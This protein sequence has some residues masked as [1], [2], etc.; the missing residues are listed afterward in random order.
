MV[1]RAGTSRQTGSRAP[2]ARLLGG[3]LLLLVLGTAPASASLLPPGFFDGPVAAGAGG[4]RVEADHMNYDAKHGLVSA[5]GAVR[6]SYQGNVISADRIEYDPATGDVTA[7]G[8]VQ[9]V[10]AGGNRYTMDSLRITGKTKEAFLD[11]L[12]ITTPEGAVITAK[13]AHYGEALQT[14]FTDATYSP[15]GLCVDSKG[16]KIGWKV[17]AAR[18]VYDRQNA[19]VSAEQPSLELL[20]VPVAWIPWFWMPDPTQPRKSGI[21]M[22][23]IGGDANRGVALT[24]PYFVPAGENIDIILSPTLMSR[25][26]FLMQGD[27]AV[28]FPGVGEIDVRGSAVDQLD[29]GAYAGTV[30]NRSWRG[31][32]QTT[33]RF[34]PAAD[35]TAGWSYSTFTDNQYL[36]DYAYDS[37][38]LLTNTLYATELS[39]QTWFDARLLSFHQLGNFT[40][41]DDNKQAL[42]VPQI[43]YDQVHDLAPGYGRLH[44]SGELLDLSRGAD[45]TATYS[46][47]P[48][49]NGNQGTKQHLMLE[50]GWEDQ[51][52][53]PG[54]VAATPYLGV[55]LD[56]ANYQRGPGAIPLGYTPTAD[57]MLL[58]ATPIA[59]IDVRWPLMARNGGDL[60]MFEP[61]GQLVYRGSDSTMVGITNDDAQSF[62][63]DDTNLF[64]YNR[65][66][67]IDRQETGLRANIGGHYS[68]NFAN[69]GWLDLI[70]GESFQIAGFNALGFA[71]TA[72]T[73]TSTGL[74]SAASFI[75]A[76]ARGGF[77]GGLTLGGKLQVDPAMPRVT[78]AG[79]GVDYTPGAHQFSAGGD[80]I[81][82]A[83]DTALG[84]PT[85]QHQVVGRVGVP[86]TDYWTANGS[87][88]YDLAAMSWADASV[89][90]SYDD[91]YLLYGASATATP[92]S[93]GIGVNLKLKGPDHADAF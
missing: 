82:V 86:I 41:S 33:G 5:L 42:V 11:T 67:G 34:T 13:D 88:T 91:G 37:S 87:L 63:F 77:D 55:R 54:G 25:Q 70:A 93:W 72:Q 16:A 56:A 69:G 32:I 48:Y 90:A 46:G 76:G 19:S 28:R 47:V 71:D 35:W 38:T 51:V 1:V 43:S 7:T 6:F 2:L 65:F 24:V 14:V 84:I 59:A 64:S 53:L 52:I 78:R 61:I 26:G 29:P 79:L 22:P 75:V 68:G 66:S 62:V 50:G 80:Y 58:S 45:D 81:F 60:H 20:G 3:L 74:G 73:E 49:V 92:T 30:G 23:S 18:I 4:A 10:D 15:C 31:A 21:R 89:G 8:H 44:F 17:R 57:A 40:Q 27:L 83:H 12:T 36:G 9:V 85:D 39:D